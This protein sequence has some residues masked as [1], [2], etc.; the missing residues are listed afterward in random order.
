MNTKNKWEKCFK[1]NCSPPIE[2]YQTHINFFGS[3]TDIEAIDR[4][5]EGI[6]TQVKLL[7]EAKSIWEKEFKNKKLW[8]TIN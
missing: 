2:V 6:G 7:K 4:R 3:N 8:K 5:I 1:I